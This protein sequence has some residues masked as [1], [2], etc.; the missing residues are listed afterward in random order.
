MGKLNEIVE[1]S[2]TRQT[3]AVSQAGFGTLL[4]VGPTVNIGT[5]DVV[6]IT[7]STDLITGNVFGAKVNGVALAGAGLT[8]ATD[9]ATTMTAIAAIIAALSTVDTCT[10][11]GD[12]LTV[13]SEAGSTVIVTDAAVT[14]GA[15]QPTTAVVRTPAERIRFYTDPDSILD[16]GFVSTDPEYIAANAAFSQ[17]PAPTT[18]AIGAMDADDADYPTALS[19]IVAVSD[20]WYGLVIVSR[21]TG[22]VGDVAAWTEARKK[23]F[24]TA[25]DDLAILTTGTTDIAA[26]LN[27]AGYDRT[28]VLFNEDAADE[29]PEAAAF[30]KLLP[31]NP[32]SMTLKF[33]SLA[34]VTY[35]P[36][37]TTESTN[38]RTK[39]CNTYESIGGVSMLREGTSASGEFVDTM[40]GSDWLEATMES[41]IF[42]RLAILPKI[43]F[44]DAGISTIEA[45][46]R[47][48]LDLGIARG[49]LAVNTDQTKYGGKKYFV[50]VPKAA[51]VS[52][53]NKAARYLPD[54]YFTATIAGAVHRT[55]VSGVIEV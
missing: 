7:F 39:K 16:D 5:R 20:D 41:N 45:E 37:T 19:A 4:V 25:S 8:F 34:G 14:G 24:G 6:T 33:K 51:D 42:S 43:P 1:V 3:R 23:I 46:I 28:F 13:T 47:R 12:V 2:I 50:E 40:I 9:H 48:T 22:D 53:V 30:G 52:A 11:L 31:V 18:V 21:D 32:G 36:I 38:A 35:S 54:L 10:A 49:F 17:N 55:T 44:T 15:T 29:Y 26:V 27:A